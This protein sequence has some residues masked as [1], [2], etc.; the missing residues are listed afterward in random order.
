MISNP[1]QINRRKKFFLIL[2]SFL[3]CLYSILTVFGQWVTPVNLGTSSPQI[4]SS[5]GYFKLICSHN[6]YLRHRSAEILSFWS[7]VCCLHVTFSKMSVCVCT[8]VH[9]ICYIY[10]LY[11][12]YIIYSLH[13]IHIHCIIFASYMI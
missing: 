13:I 11:I 7:S 9:C 8:Y 3:C 1:I 2:M 12:L 10:S 6:I 4:F 5:L